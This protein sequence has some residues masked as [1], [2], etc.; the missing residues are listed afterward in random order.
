[1]RLSAGLWLSSKKFSRPRMFTDLTQITAAGYSSG[2]NSFI[3]PWNDVNLQHNSMYCIVVF[4]SREFWRANWGTGCPRQSG[5]F[6]KNGAPGLEMYPENGNRNMRSLLSFGFFLHGN[7]MEKS[8][9]LDVLWIG[10]G[11]QGLWNA[12]FGFQLPRLGRC[13]ILPSENT[14]VTLPRGSAASDSSWLCHASWSTPH[15]KLY[16]WPTR[17]EP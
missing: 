13:F 12:E 16:C 14:W 7:N 17:R 1:M 3:V 6:L 5:I 11:L 15:P 4:L 9:Q 8:E 10:G 2:I